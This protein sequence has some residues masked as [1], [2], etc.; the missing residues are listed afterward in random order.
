MLLN[1]YL[2][3]L[4]SEDMLTVWKHRGLPPGPFKLPGSTEAWS[5]WVQK[6]GHQQHHQA[7]GRFSKQLW[8]QTMA[9]HA[10]RHRGRPCLSLATAAC[11]SARQTPTKLVLSI[12]SRQL[13]HQ[14]ELTRAKINVGE[15]AATRTP[16]PGQFALEAR[17]PAGRRHQYNLLWLL[18]S[19]LKHTYPQDRLLSTE[20]RRCMLCGRWTVHFKHATL[21]NGSN[22]ATVAV[23]CLAAGCRTC[24]LLTGD[25]A[26]SLPSA[27]H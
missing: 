7:D 25:Q 2:E 22:S 12:T 23:P 13:W 26:A 21:Q 8:Q 10:G 24:R 5:S 6:A 4:Y 18:G 11:K 9:Q 27:Q 17:H 16:W 1:L 20:H 14:V 19:A 15:T 3:D